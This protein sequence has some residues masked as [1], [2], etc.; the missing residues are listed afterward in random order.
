MPAATVPMPTQGCVT[1][2]EVLP[3]LG[4][5]QLKRVPGHSGSSLV[6]RPAIMLLD[7]QQVT[8]MQG[9]HLSEGGQL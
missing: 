7:Q 3:G 9:A 2:E 5:S 1:P 4:R 8:A 6:V